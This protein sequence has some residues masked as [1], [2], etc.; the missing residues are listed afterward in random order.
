M[1]V[2]ECR[3]KKLFLNIFCENDLR[4]FAHDKTFFVI[5][6]HIHFGKSQKSQKVND[7]QICLE[8]TFVPKKQFLNF[9]TYLCT[10]LY[11]NPY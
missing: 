2:E 9:G 8:N 3:P 6:Y 7:T 10:Y 1:K 4:L 5:T 11:E